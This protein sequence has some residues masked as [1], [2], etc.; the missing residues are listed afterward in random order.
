MNLQASNEAYS[1][2]V[3]TAYRREPVIIETLDFGVVGE[4]MGLVIDELTGDTV[5]AHWD[6][7]PALHQPAG[8]LH[9]GAHAW[10]VETLASVGAMVWLGDRGTAVG[11]SNQTDFYRAV[12]QG[13]LTSVATPVHRGRRQQV[14]LVETSDAE[15]RLIAR[16]QLRLQNLPPD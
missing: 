10:V 9:G 16:G 5:R 3:A 7:T 4:A 1:A 12:S 2:T 14:W 13:R 8:I 15:H 6:A 11:V